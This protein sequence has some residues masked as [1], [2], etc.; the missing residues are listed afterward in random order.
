MHFSR[1]YKTEK[2]DLINLSLIT[3]MYRQSYNVYVV[4]FVGGG[5]C[6]VSEKDMDGIFKIFRN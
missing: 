4:E 6:T 1:F 5:V 2:G 3:R